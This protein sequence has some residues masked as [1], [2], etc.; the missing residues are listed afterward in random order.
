[1]EAPVKSECGPVRNSWKSLIVAGATVLVA[2]AAGVT[3]LVTGIGTVLVTGAGTTAFA[4]APTNT[5]TPAP[6]PTPFPG[7]VC[8]SSTSG[9]SDNSC[10]VEATGFNSGNPC[11]ANDV[12]ISTLPPRGTSCR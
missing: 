6:T 3:V 1:M 9:S 11:Q 7:S 8:D 12:R 10:L 5:P 2:G 4:A